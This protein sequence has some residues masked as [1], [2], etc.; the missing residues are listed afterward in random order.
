MTLHLAVARA[1]QQ[2]PRRPA[3]RGPGYERSWAETADRIARL[4]SGLL[5]HGLAPGDRLAILAGNSAEHLEL[6]IAA[7]GAGI[8]IVPLNLRL[9]TPELAE[10]VQDAGALALACDAAN[11]ARG[12]EL[13]A[14]AGITAIR[15]ES[16]LPRLLAAPPAPL[17][18]VSGDA[19]FGL[20]YTGG[21]T[22]RPKGVMLTHRILHLC[23]I[24]QAVGMECG[25][26][27]VHLQAAPLFHLAGFTTGNSVTYMQGTHVYAD[28]L[29]PAG[30]LSAIETQGVN[31]LSVVPT[32][33][34]ALIDLAG[35]ESPVLARVK[36]VIYGAAPPSPA[37][38]RDMMA[39]FPNARIKQAYGQTEIGG[40]CA[41]LPAE[42]HRPG[43]PKLG[44][45]GLATLS[46]PLRIVGPEGR[47]LPRGTAGEIAVTGPRVMAGYWNL[48]EQTAATVVDGWLHTG[49]V[50]VMDEDGYLTVVDR[51]KDMIVTGGENV[52]CGEVEAVLSR[53]PSVSQVAVVGVPDPKWGEA[54]HAFV[55]LKPGAAPDPAALADHA[56]AEVAGY[57][58]PKGVTFLDALPLSGVGKVRK[59]DLRTL[60]Q[61]RAAG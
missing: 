61:E 32:V 37:L 13:C 11:A 60:W 2:S 56:R 55:V 3:L 5:A 36:D 42:V 51:L 28:D 52:F 44:A 45:T 9:A 54:V 48:P 19:L 31:F 46:V 4:S 1:A 41:I 47:E 38:M 59:G 22:G 18:D 17:A 29:S 34:R 21:T 30:I 57:K 15:I 23:A 8:V 40:A 26:E 7:V 20:Y 50:G 24:D 14:G 53:H 49:D 58:V 35:M 10:I 43:H 25:P 33:F 16:G 27:T 6:T 39:A 12:A